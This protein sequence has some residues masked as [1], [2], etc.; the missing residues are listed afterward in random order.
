[1]NLANEKR[2][3]L[4]SYN[5]IRYKHFLIN[6]PLLFINNIRYKRLKNREDLFLVI[7][8]MYARECINGYFYLLPGLT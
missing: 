8:K 4:K 2:D 6:N 5:K 7:R 1:M 3:I